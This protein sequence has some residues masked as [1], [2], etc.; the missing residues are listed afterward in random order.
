M[1][2]NNIKTLVFWYVECVGRKMEKQEN[3]SG[4]GHIMHRVIQY[5]WSYRAVG[6]QQKTATA[7]AAAVAVS[8]CRS[9]QMP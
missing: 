2:K 6:E 4:P 7:S 9:Q 8:S 3:I 1:K 5:L